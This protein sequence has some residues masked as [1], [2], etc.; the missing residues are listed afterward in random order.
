MRKIWALVTIVAAAVG[1]EAISAGYTLVRGLWEAHEKVE[2]TQDM[3]RDINKSFAACSAGDSDKCE[4]G[5]LQLTRDAMKA[6]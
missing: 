3:K 1:F 6:E 5:A 4:Q 2:A